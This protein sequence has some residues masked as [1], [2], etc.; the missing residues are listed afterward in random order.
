MLRTVEGSQ[1]ET[2]VGGVRVVCE[3]IDG[4]VAIT[5]HTDC[6]GKQSHAQ[7]SS[8][9]LRERLQGQEFLRFEHVD[10][11]HHVT[12]ARAP[13]ALAREGLVVTG[14][15]GELAA[16]LRVDPDR[17]SGSIGDARTQRYGMAGADGMNGIGEDDYVTV[18]LG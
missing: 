1:R 8:M 5:I 3:H 18:A 13:A 10:A 2:R 4:A 16:L 12:V 6:A 9:L 17:L 14:E 15:L 11:G 7:M